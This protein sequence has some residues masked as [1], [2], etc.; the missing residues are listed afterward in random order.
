[1]YINRGK[2]TEK[3]EQS[4]RD[5]VLKYIEDY[6]LSKEEI[7]DMY[8]NCLI[9]YRK[10]QMTIMHMVEDTDRMVQRWEKGEVTDIR[11]FVFQ[12]NTIIEEGT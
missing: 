11:E 6:K 12:P 10:D 1:M 8:I 7:V 5:E 3:A 9:A 2:M 4:V